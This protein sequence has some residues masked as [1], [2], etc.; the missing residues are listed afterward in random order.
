[1]CVVHP[2]DELKI[3]NLKQTC[4]LLV[5]RVE[6]GGKR[7]YYLTEQTQR[8]GKEAQGGEQAKGGEE[9]IF[10]GDSREHAREK[11]LRR[12]RRQREKKGS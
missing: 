12:R 9:A 5:D 8:R 6:R 7:S 4:D 11:E 3:K 1:L 10:Y 2:H